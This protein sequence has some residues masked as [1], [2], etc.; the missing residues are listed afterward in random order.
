MTEGLDRFAELK[1]QI[2]G[3]HNL[4]PDSQRVSMLAALSLAQER[5]IEGMAAGRHTDYSALAKVIELLDKY[6]P[7]IIPKVQISFVGRDGNEM[8]LDELRAADG[9]PPI[10]ALGQNQT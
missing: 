4:P 10:D 8:T 1:A 9:L 6:V 7:P 2:A 5:M 3:T